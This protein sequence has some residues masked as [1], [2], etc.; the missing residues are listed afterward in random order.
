MQD[1]CEACMPLAPRHA[2][3][4]LVGRVCNAHPADLGWQK[5]KAGGGR[6]CFVYARALPQ[7]PCELVR[8]SFL[9]RTGQDEVV[10][11]TG[12]RYTRLKT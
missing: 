6:L 7:L 10:G 12:D 9:E 4:Q 5:L 2:Q 11:Y 3:G 1:P 8:M